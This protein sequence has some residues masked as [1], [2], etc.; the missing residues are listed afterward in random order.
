MNYPISAKLVTDVRNKFNLNHE[1]LG[2]MLNKSRTT[3]VN[4][5]AGRINIPG[6]IVLKLQ[7]LLK[8][9]D[10]KQ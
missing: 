9:A 5:Q 3:I 8:G 1:Q 7:E 6:D 10:G 2:E 4:Y